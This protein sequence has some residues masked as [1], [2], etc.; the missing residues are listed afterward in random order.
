MMA[1]LGTEL[2]GEVGALGSLILTLGFAVI[3]GPAFGNDASVAKRE[4]KTGFLIG[5]RNES[6]ENI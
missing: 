3:K 2:P 1:G 4:T 5:E 6:N